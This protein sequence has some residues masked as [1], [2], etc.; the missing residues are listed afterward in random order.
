MSGITQ[1]LKLKNIHKWSTAQS[2]EP[3]FITNHI[4]MFPAN[5]CLFHLSQFLES[6]I[7]KTTL[8]YTLYEILLVGAREFMTCFKTNLSGMLQTTI[9]KL[10]IS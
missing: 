10:K 9:I 4:F 2:L 1:V 3:G 6:F 7:W 5:W 8:R